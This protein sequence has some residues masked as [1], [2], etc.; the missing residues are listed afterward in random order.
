MDYIIVLVVGITAF[1]E[2]IFADTLLFSLFFVKYCRTVTSIL[3]AL[4][5]LVSC[6]VLCR[7]PIT[8]FV[9]IDRK[10]VNPSLSS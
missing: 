10:S 6:Y 3:V 1:R 7:N 8:D 5:M 2:I 9:N 4:L